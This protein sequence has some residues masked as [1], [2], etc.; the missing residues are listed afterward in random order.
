MDINLAKMHHELAQQ[1]AAG[2]GRALAAGDERLEP[3]AQS[4]DD[5]EHVYEVVRELREKRYG[6]RPHP[7][8]AACLHGLAIVGYYRAALLG[9]AGALADAAGYA[10]AAL[11]QRLRIA[12]SLTGLATPAALTDPDVRK[13]VDLLLKITAAAM[14]ARFTDVTDGS[15]A[16]TKVLQEAIREWLQ[17]PGRRPNRSRS[18]QL[19]S[20]SSTMPASSFRTV[21]RRRWTSRPCRA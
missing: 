14:L 16:V 4:L 6:G 13:S 9:Q 17:G 3:A 12:G 21:S 2:S 5:A 18:S 8:L 7:H 1:A 11:D 15:A 19:C 10:S 20:A